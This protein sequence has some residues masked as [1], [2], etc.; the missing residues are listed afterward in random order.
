MKLRLSLLAHQFL[1]HRFRL[2]KA[3][4]LAALRRAVGGTKNHRLGAR[5]LSSNRSAELV[6]GR[7][8]NDRSNY[9]KFSRSTGNCRHFR[10]AP[11]G[12]V[13]PLTAIAGLA[14]IRWA[15][16]RA[17]EW[18]SFLGAGCYLTGMLLSVVFGI[19]PMVLPALNSAYR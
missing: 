11:W 9:R 16:D 18:K 14:G 7:R 6:A 1:S 17:D 2:C 8:A 4:A 5:S 15:M 3:L 13:F 12:Y 19:F 10:S